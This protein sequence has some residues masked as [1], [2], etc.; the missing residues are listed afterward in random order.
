MLS[1]TISHYISIQRCAA[2]FPANG[3]EHSHAG[4][5]RAL[6]SV[7][8]GATSSEK[9]CGCFGFS[10]HKQRASRMDG[11]PFRIG[12]TR[13]STWSCSSRPHLRTLWHHLGNARTVHPDPC[14][15]R[16]GLRF[17]RGEEPTPACAS[18]HSPCPWPPSAPLGHRNFQ[19][20]PSTASF[21]PPWNTVAA[22]YSVSQQME[23]LSVPALWREIP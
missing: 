23:W 1:Y 17:L 5:K 15:A 8:Y 4:T 18:L 10:Q 19:E 6:L 20:P 12:I 22:W 16:G 7:A 21:R 13:H 2:I 9:A 14:P 11:F 3:M